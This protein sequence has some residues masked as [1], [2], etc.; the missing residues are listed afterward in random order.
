VPYQFTFQTLAGFLVDA[1]AN[2]AGITSEDDEILLFMAVQ[3]ADDTSD[4]P[5][6]IDGFIQATSADSGPLEPSA[7]FPYT[8]GGSEGLAVDVTGQFLGED[9]EG[10][11]AVVA[12][13][14]A[15]LFLA[16]GLAV[17]GR[18]PEEGALLFEETLATVS[19]VPQTA[20]P[21]TATTA[22]TA[23]TATATAAATSSFPLPIPTGAPAAE[24]QGIPIMTQ[25]IA[26]SDNGDSYAFT[27]ATSKEEVRQFYE[28]AMAGIGW[29]LLS[30]GEGANGALLMIFQQEGGVASVSIFTLD[31]STTYVFLVK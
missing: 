22:A 23:P 21:P 11:I 16:Y 14:E 20:A 18:W 29:S 17:N 15:R 25:A 4:L 6:V 19:F 7:S 1:Q 13:D 8:I 24:W 5:S 27:I 28:G 30:V 3:T 10:R 2:Q 9:V 26:G 12:A 31:S